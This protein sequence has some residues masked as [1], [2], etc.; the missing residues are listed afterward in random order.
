MGI[1]M[2]IGNPDVFAIE[3]ISTDISGQCH[4]IFRIQKHEIGDS[5]VYTELK[6]CVNWAIEFL[7][8]SEQ[9]KEFN[10]YKIT[11]NKLMFDLHDVIFRV[12][13]PDMTWDELS[14][15][16]QTFHMDDIGMDSFRDRFSIILVHIGN[17][18]ERIIW[19]DDRQG[20][21]NNVQLPLGEVDAVLR[22]FI[23]QFQG[24]YK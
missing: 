16:R 6:G 2:I 20:V 1:K 17:S 8:Y 21:I 10:A 14:N 7:K 15:F 18:L 3:I 19:R 12:K 9:R 23:A 11:P 24:N 22:E 13:R 4:F 5:S